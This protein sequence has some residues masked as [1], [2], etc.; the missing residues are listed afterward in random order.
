MLL[1][2][3]NTIQT[4]NINVRWQENVISEHCILY[5]IYLIPIICIHKTMFVI[6][7]WSF[8]MEE[9]SNHYFGQS[10]EQLVEQMAGTHCSLPACTFYHY[11]NNI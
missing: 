5:L 1:R 7:V 2:N 11:F 10:R 9:N 4:Y 6:S 3:I 8:L